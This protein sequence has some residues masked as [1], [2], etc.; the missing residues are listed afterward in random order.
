MQLQPQLLLMLSLQPSNRLLQRHAQLQL[1]AAP[2]ASQS[3]GAPAV[4]TAMLHSTGLLLQ[5]M[6]QQPA[7]R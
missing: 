3:P 7:M 2:T 6:Q 4:Q 5:L 1:K